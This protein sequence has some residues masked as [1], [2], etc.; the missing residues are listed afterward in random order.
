MGRHRSL[1]VTHIVNR[2]LS[3]VA[4]SNFLCYLSLFGL[5]GWVA[6]T[7]HQAVVRTSPLAKEVFVSWGTQSLLRGL[8]V[9]YCSCSELNKLGTHSKFWIIYTTSVEKGESYMSI[10]ESQIHTF[11]EYDVKYNWRE[12]KF[13]NLWRTH[14]IV[15]F[16]EV[17][18]YRILKICPLQSNFTQIADRLTNRR[19]LMGGTRP[20]KRVNGFSSK[21]ILEATLPGTNYRTIL[22]EGF[23]WILHRK[24]SYPKNH[25][26]IRDSSLFFGFIPVLEKS[27]SWTSFT[28]PKKRLAEEVLWK[29]DP[30]K[31]KKRPPWK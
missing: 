7:S 2:S 14:T 24:Q 8:R 19:W 22:L 3:S 23:Q 15:I 20:T 18:R 26:L 21:K 1:L 12:S 11:T 27:L 31:T 5:C 16:Y 29:R 25:T 10:I 13:Q 30:P 28:E 6:P 17:L 4:A 9:L